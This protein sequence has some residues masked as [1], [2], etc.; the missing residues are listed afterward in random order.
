[1]YK[2]ILLLLI[3]TGFALNVPDGYSPCGT[4]INL[5]DEE[6]EANLREYHSTKDEIL[7]NSVRD[8]NFVQAQVHI[9]HLDDGSGGIPEWTVQ[10]VLDEINIDYEP[11]N[12]YFYHPEPINHINSSEYYIC[13]NDA[14]LD[15]IRTI[16][17][18]PAVMDIFIVNDA[19]AGPNGETPICGISTFT[20]YG[21]QGMVIAA[22]CWDHE[23]G[24]H[25]VG[26]YFDL[27]HTHNPTA[28]Y[29]D[30]T[31]CNYRG[32]GLCDTPADPD[33]SIAGMLSGCEYAGTENNNAT[34][35]MGH[36][37]DGQECMGYATCAEYGG[38]DTKN[39]MSYNLTPG[40][41]DHFTEDQLEK[42]EVILLSQRPEYVR[43]PDYPY[44]NLMQVSSTNLVGDDDG[45]IN[46]GE[47]VELVYNVQIPEVWPTGGNDLLFTLTTDNENISISNGD[48][49][50]SECSS[51]GTYSNSNSPVIIEFDSSIPLG[52]YDFN[53]EIQ[54]TN[55]QK[56]SFDLDVSLQQ[57]GFP[58]VSYP[59]SSQV[60]TSP[61]VVDLDGDGMN[62]IVFGDNMGR[63]QVL[64]E[65]GQDNV[66]P[67]FP[68]ETGGF[69]LGSPASAD[70]DGDGLTEFVVCSEDKSLY[71]FDKDGLVSEYVTSDFLLATPAIGNID[72]D[73]DFEIIVGGYSDGAMLYAV[74]ADGTD[75]N[76]FPYNIDERI[77][78]GVALADFNGNGKDDIVFG[79][80]DEN[81]YLLLDDATLAPG[82]PFEVGGDIQSAPS[83]LSIDGEKIIFFGSKDD[84]LYSVSSSGSLRFSIETDGN[85][86]TSPALVDFDDGP[87][88]FFGTDS[89]T[90]YGIDMY[91]NLLEGWPVQLTG[92]LGSVTFAD[93]GSDSSLEI[94]VGTNDGALYILNADGSEFSFYPV[95]DVTS[96][97][98]S[99][100]I[101]DI[102]GDMDLEILIGT[103]TGL[104]VYDE[105]V[106]S[107]AL[108]DWSMYRANSFRNGVYESSFELTC[109]AG[110]I[111]GDEISDILDIIQLVNIIVGS[112][113]PSA[114]QSCA[115]DMDA[116]GI[117]DILDIIQLVNLITS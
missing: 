76:G 34:D 67:S 108:S 116:N 36:Y 82:F 64:G 14:E 1:M 100:A 88:I 20:W 117:I 102:D 3:G 11:A 33:L 114:D 43:E 17:D 28:E 112:M 53:I 83:V 49:Y 57:Y 101:A 85:I 107:S 86:Y 89:G 71:I 38:P 13:D 94:I 113:E 65:A 109:E 51:G 25:E 16:Y 4:T 90:L 8:M 96:F 40:C 30:G 95:F 35:G 92:A 44:F 39:I 56:I 59:Y 104:S 61:L 29:V 9:V 78:R 79:T 12:I 41:T 18:T 68:Y 58:F 80:D 5:S 2:K 99:N 27:Y 75:V 93:I 110:D 115:A 22:G 26:H 46:P 55:L 69:V 50:L 42:A 111:N 31:G 21:V 37:Y 72:D 32:D 106:T 23:T 48:F 77:K 45:V 105:K 15:A 103:D 63:V 19:S 24:S 70:L 47:T 97:S 6:F 91:G 81:I 66:F 62:E 7:S 98:G 73:S 87:A 60:K 10:P 52:S 84:F 54:S 74:N